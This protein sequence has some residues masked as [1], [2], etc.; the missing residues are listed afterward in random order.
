LV[1]LRLA[2][3]ATRKEEALDGTHESSERRASVALSE[4]SSGEAADKVIDAETAH[5]F[6]AQAEARGLVAAHDEA[7]AAH[8]LAVLVIGE[9]AGPERF[10]RAAVETAEV[11][12]VLSSS[13]NMMSQKSSRAASG[14]MEKYQTPH[15]S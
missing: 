14:E 11:I 6:V 2:G 15:W 8:D 1:A 12:R 13:A 3:S 7:P 10:S 4:V 9:D 5:G